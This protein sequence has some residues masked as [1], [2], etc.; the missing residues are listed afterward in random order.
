MRGLYLRR[1]A[2]GKKE[3]KKMRYSL[4][5][6]VADETDKSARALANVKKLTEV[7]EPDLHVLEIVDILKN[8]EIAVE[9]HIIA[10]PALI[11][12]LPLPVRRV[13]GD[14]S[15]RESVIYALGMAEIIK[16]R[17]GDL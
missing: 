16:S 10:I 8:P 7:L 13:I 11:R 4:K 17:A 12:K 15:D 6:Y 1:V 2:L 5:L 14:L 3:E 9:D